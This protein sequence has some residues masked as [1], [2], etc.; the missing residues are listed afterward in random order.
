MRLV[1]DEAR[2]SST[3]RGGPVVRRVREDDWRVLRGVRLAALANAPM[4]F[5]SSLPREQVFGEG[6]W[7][8]WTRTSGVF[9]AVVADSPVGMA[10]GI[11]GQSRAERNL[12]AMW[13]NSLWRGQGAASLLVDSV[14][15]WARSEGAEQ[16]RLWVADGNESARRFYERRGFSV[17]GRRTDA[18]QPSIVP[19]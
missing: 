12:V 6:R 1:A 14:A 9:I 13:V 5:G 4:A 19:G 16:L 2:A 17:T 18:R 3:D 10:A 7:R 8:A 15:G 11:S